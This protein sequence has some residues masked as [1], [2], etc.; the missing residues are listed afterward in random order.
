M[1][2]KCEKGEIASADREMD[3]PSLDNGAVEQLQSL[4]FQFSPEAREKACSEDRFDVSC[5]LS[6]AIFRC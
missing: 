3:R 5:L 6:G 2:E 4:S 1:A